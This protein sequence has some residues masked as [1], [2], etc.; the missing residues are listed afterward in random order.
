[1]DASIIGKMDAVKIEFMDSIAILSNS[2]GTLD[3]TNLIGAKNTEKKTG[4]PV[5]KLI[6]SINYLFNFFI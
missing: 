6:F 3:D 4:I 5:K 1:L 2:V